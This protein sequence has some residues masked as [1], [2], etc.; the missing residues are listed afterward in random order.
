MHAEEIQ[1]KEKT[2]A[3]AHPSFSEELRQVWNALPEKGFFFG[4]LGVWVIVFQFFGNSQFN[5]TDGPSLFEWLWGA[6]HTEALDASHG[7]LIPPVVL[8]ILWYKREELLASIK[9]VWWPA[10]FPLGIAL[11]LHLVG[12]IIQQPRGSV[13][14]LFLSLYSLVGLTW[15]WKTMK[16][17]FFPFILFAYCMPLGTF[18]EKLT[19]HLQLMAAAIT[20]FI[21]RDLMGIPLIRQGT[22]LIDTN[23]KFTY[24]VGVAC[25][26]IRS[27]FALLAITT[28]FAMILF[29]T[30]WRRTLMIFYAIPLAIFCNVLRLTAIVLGAQGFGSK[31][32]DFVHEWFGFITYAISIAAVMLLSHFLRES[33]ACAKP[34]AACEKTSS[35]IA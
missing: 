20:A 35:S 27:L 21:T 9:G 1:A 32:G 34:I 7:T 18:V 24:D 11:L 23:G 3:P 19:F 10:L 17:S 28:I 12:F 5:F 30:P 25:S 31:A 6:W 15:G 22:Q 13:I 33:P 2:D 4:L 8:A 16:A 14:A 29:K 26:G